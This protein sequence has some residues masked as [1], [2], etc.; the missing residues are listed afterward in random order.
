MGSNRRTG[1]EWIAS[2]RRRL[3][4]IPVAGVAITAGLALGACGSPSGGTPT[5]PSA[6]QK[7]VNTLIGQGLSQQ[8]A[9]NY[10]QAETYY[11]QALAIQPANA[12]ALY[13]LGLCQQLTG[14][15][16]DA[17]THYR[18]ALA[19]NPNFV[20]ALFNLATVVTQSAPSEAENLYQQI[21][22]IEP[23]YANAHLNLGF[24]LRSLGQITA[25]NKQL[26]KAVQ[27]DPKLSSRVQGIIPTN[28]TGAS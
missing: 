13:D 16:T 15:A 7:Q 11:T 20:A 18:A 5:G 3:R 22:Q 17:E 9:G 28:A 19:V 24:V 12:A 21:I 8:Q 4:V 6:Q 23:N 25:G 1:S 27:I 2:A 26:Q 10:S 14:D